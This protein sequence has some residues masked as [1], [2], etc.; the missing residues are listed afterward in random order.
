[1]YFKQQQYTW[2]VMRIA[3][4]ENVLY[5]SRI[6]GAS[7][8]LEILHVIQLNENNVVFLALQNITNPYI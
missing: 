1:M 4:I 6:N 2:I 5:N 8:E 3:T 7:L